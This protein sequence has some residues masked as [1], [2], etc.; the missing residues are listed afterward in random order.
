VSHYATSGDSDLAASYWLELINAAPDALVPAATIAEILPALKRRQAQA[1]EE[2]ASALRGP[3]RRAMRHAVHPRNGS[4][5]PGVA[6]RL[7][8]EGRTINPEAARRAA[9][10]ALQS[11]HLDATKRARI[12]KVLSPESA[13]RFALVEGVPVSLGEEAIVLRGAQQNELRIPYKG[14]EAIAVAEVAGLA[15]NHVVLIDLVRQLR[16]STDGA[17]PINVARI[18]CDAFDPST[19]IDGPC[20]PGAELTAFLGELLERTQAASL[21]S[22]DSALGLQFARYDSLAEYQREVLSIA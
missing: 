18:R 3:L 6:M 2:E 19:L 15:E 16:N 4:L 20:L 7:F 10:A 9:Q 11:P 14:I 5:H 17:E 22:L 21:P 13:S 8:E 1:D 12:E